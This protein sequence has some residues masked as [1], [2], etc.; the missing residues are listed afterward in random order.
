[1]RKRNGRNIEKNSPKR[2][3][4]KR[5]L[6][7]GKTHPFFES[8]VA[9]CKQSGKL[10]GSWM[11][12]AKDTWADYVWQDESGLEICFTA[13]LKTRAKTVRLWTDCYSG[14]QLLVSAKK[15]IEDFKRDLREHEIGIAK[16]ASQGRIH[17]ITRLQL[18]QQPER[19]FDILVECHHKLIEFIQRVKQSATS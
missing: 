6:I 3:V 19:S 1:M 4:K 8:F 13:N 17:F 15:L 7:P 11:P 2:T 9:Y 16:I 12:R 18:A 14:S 10:T 5:N